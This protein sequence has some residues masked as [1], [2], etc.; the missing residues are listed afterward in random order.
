M[1]EKEIVEA[2]LLG[3]GEDNTIAAK[4]VLIGGEIVGV[5]IENID[6]W[7]AIVDS[8]GKEL[9]S[10][11]RI[12]VLG[13]GKELVSTG[14]ISVLG[15]TVESGEPITVVETLRVTGGELWSTDDDNTAVEILELM[16]GT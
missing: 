12:S 3:F 4:E 8:F 10:T 7:G 15:A 2:I 9:V 6:E 14:R 1:T 5:L 13:F 16:T 11:G